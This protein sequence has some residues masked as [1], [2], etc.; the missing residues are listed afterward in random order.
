MPLHARVGVPDEEAQLERIGITQQDRHAERS[1]ARPTRSFSISNAMCGLSLPIHAPTW[2]SYVWKILR[3]SG[4]VV[5]AAACS[6]ML[7]RWTVVLFA[8]MDARTCRFRWARGSV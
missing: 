3:R 2:K 4:S 8:V 5:P 6:E 7:L 1:L